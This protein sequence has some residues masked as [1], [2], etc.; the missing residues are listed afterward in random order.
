MCASQSEPGCRVIEAGIP[1]RGRV[2]T[3]TGLRE[4]CLHVIRVG[5]ALEIFQVARRTGCVGDAVVTVDV[6][7]GTL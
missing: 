4:S 6:A 7:L 3:L 2:A 5:C 1:V